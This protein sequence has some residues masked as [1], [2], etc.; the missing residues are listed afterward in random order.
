[1]TW[2]SL[3][4]NDFVELPVCELYGKVSLFVSI[5]CLVEKLQMAVFFQIPGE[6]QYLVLI[7]ATNLPMGQ[8]FNLLPGRLIK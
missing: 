7:I 3:E 4:M 6:S 1:M 2:W 8:Y 5:C